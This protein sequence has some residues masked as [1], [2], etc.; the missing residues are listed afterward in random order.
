MNVISQENLSLLDQRQISGHWHPILQNDSSLFTVVNRHFKD[1]YKHD[2]S[3]STVVQFTSP[4]DLLTKI[5]DLQAQLPHGLL[6]TMHLRNSGVAS[7]EVRVRLMVDV[8]RPIYEY[9]ETVLNDSGGV[10]V[11]S[12]ISYLRLMLV[13]LAQLSYVEEFY[14]G[15]CNYCPVW[16][17]ENQ[18]GYSCVDLCSGRRY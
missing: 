1:T 5:L 2:L 10:R 11:S 12:L 8:L 17:I 9:T 6:D 3:R 7:L 4:Q 16:R 18:K 14:C 15:R 13:Q